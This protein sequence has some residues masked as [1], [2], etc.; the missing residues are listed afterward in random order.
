M[1]KEMNKLHKRIAKYNMICGLFMSL[2]IGLIFNLQMAVIFLL[3]VIIGLLGYISR[4]IVVKKWIGKGTFGILF[5][6]LI[7]ICLVVALL[8]P[9][10]ND[11]EL[12]I[13]YLAGF[14]LNFIVEGYCIKM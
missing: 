7:R 6:T 9:F 14:I 10:I 1:S 11:M 4:V 12:V 3:G 5:T 8:L 13:A 2:I